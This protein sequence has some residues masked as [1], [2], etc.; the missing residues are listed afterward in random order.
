MSNEKI[1]KIV[2]SAGAIAELIYAE[3]VMNQFELFIKIF[4][5]NVHVT[6]FVDMNV[7][8]IR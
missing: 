7:A 4:F 1:Q 8:L 3:M 2:P 6:A 5:L